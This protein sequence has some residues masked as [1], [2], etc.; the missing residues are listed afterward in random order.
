MPYS[1]V[2]QPILRYFLQLI[3]PLCKW[4]SFVSNQQKTITEVVKKPWSTVP[5]IYLCQAV[6][7]RVESRQEG[8]EK[9]LTNLCTILTSLGYKMLGA[10]DACFGML[11]V[12]GGDGLKGKLCSADH[13]AKGWDY[14]SLFESGQFYHKPQMLDLEIEP[15]VVCQMEF[16]LPLDRDWEFLNVPQFSIFEWACLFCTIECWIWISCAYCV[17]AHGSDIVSSL[18]E[19]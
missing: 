13:R 3:I 14:L 15:A 2:H 11:Q 9:P 7:V 12:W 17:G 18:L 19:M 1:L 10:W 8:S 4:L 5:G 6:W 16:G